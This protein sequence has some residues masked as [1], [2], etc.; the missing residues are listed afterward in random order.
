MDWRKYE[1]EIFEAFKTAY[2]NAKISFNQKIVGR[3]SKIER[4]VDVLVEGRIAGKK[5]RLV[6]D[7]K[8]YSENIDVKGVD[9]FISMVEDIDAVQG[10][11]VTSKGYSEGAINR[12]YYGPTDIE[13]DILNF[14]ELKQFQ[15]FGGITYSGQHGAIIPAPFGWVVDGT[16]RVECVATLYQRGKTFELAAKSGEFIYVNI[17]SFDEKVKNLDDVI[18]LQ[19]EE[20]L[21]YHPKST[22]EYTDSIERSDKKRT[23]L[24]KI[25]REE[26]NLEEYTAFAEFDNFCVFC[27][28]FTP[29]QLKAKNIRKLE[30]VIERLIPINV[31]QNSIIDARI[32]DLRELLKKTESNQ[33]K[34][35][36]LI[37]I[38]KTYRSIKDLDKATTA[39]KESVLIF[40]DNY[41]A[42]LGL[43]EI[44]YNTDNRNN[45]IET[46]YNL[47]PGNRQLC[48]DIIRLGIENN[49]IEFTEQL[50][51]TKVDNQ[52]DKEALGNIY[53]SLA[54][55]FYTVEKYAKA[56]EYF[57]K[58]KVN[59]SECFNEQH[60]AFEAI[61]K[62]IIELEMKRKE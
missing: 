55:L 51:L 53:F 56:L 36:I 1:N 22:F 42:N 40:P 8:Y 38:A 17:F 37:E 6:I 34:A 10:I 57:R 32:S 3:Y 47:A 18:K 7:G 27:V 16:K 52:K 13:L 9:S 20:T 46:F 2:P 21:H 24:R 23:L 11:L 61:N 45:L 62:A 44:G 4:Q 28:L 50:L 60:P 12:A 43:L 59:F 49:E 14:E 26:T 29:E 35:E 39:Y 31:D 5:I 33:E 54:D 15:G 58:A 30:Y 41:G 48:D 19:E 25:L